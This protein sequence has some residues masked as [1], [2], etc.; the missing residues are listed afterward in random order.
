M[1]FVCACV[2]KDLYVTLSGEFSL[3]DTSCIIFARVRVLKL[4]VLLI[5]IGLI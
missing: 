4:P 5:T 2:G 1:A 3:K